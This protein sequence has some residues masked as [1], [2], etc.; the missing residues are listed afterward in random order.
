LSSLFD[1]GKFSWVGGPILIGHSTPDLHMVAQ[2]PSGFHIIHLQLEFPASTRVAN[3]MLS[4]D[5]VR[6]V[7]RAV[8][9]DLPCKGKLQR[10]K[11][12]LLC[13]SLSFHNLFY[14][15]NA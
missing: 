15:T 5:V 9:T 7:L 11:S 3:F 2:S 13:T 4:F 6:H 14:S 1:W 10:L 8:E 12:Q